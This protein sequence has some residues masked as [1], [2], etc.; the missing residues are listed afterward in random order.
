MTTHCMIVDTPLGPV[1]IQ[2]TDRAVTHLA[3]VAPDAP[4]DDRAN[5]SDTPVA[6]AARQL[7][8]YF[9]GRRE[10]FDLPLAPDGTVFQQ[11]VWQALRDIPRRQTRS[12][13]DIAKMLGQPG[14]ARAVGLANAR[15]PIA[16]VIPC[17]RVIGAND[18]LTGYAGGMTRKIWLLTHEGHRVDASRQ[19]LAR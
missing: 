14:A 4:L 12:Y 9:S 15:N 11:R 3:F 8:A 13:G 7:R 6:E 17:H 1:H 18:R 16:I 5:A 2:G 10:A 19:R